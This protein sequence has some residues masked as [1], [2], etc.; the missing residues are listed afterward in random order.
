MII[1]YRTHIS[2][3]GLFYA[4]RELYRLCLSEPYT[5]NTQN[6]FAMHSILLS[7]QLLGSMA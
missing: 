3:W 6:T 7:G 2:V 5:F 1:C 4:Y